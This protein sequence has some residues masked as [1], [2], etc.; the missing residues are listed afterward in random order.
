LNILNKSVIDAGSTPSN[1]NAKL[2]DEGKSS[3]S[4]ADTTMKTPCVV[5]GQD[6]E[7][8]ASYIDEARGV[9]ILEECFKNGY[10]FSLWTRLGWMARNPMRPDSDEKSHLAIH[11]L[12]FSLLIF[13][14]AAIAVFAYFILK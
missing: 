13:G 5:L 14:V 11:P 9:E 8:K 3:T 2:P 6:E 7:G 10:R 1:S 12:I 4:T